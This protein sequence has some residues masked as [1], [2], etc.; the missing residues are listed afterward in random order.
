MTTIEPRKIVPIAAKISA[1]K[2]YFLNVIY[3][4][5]FL[6]C[7]AGIGTKFINIIRYNP[8]IDQPCFYHLNVEKDEENYIFKK[9]SKYE[10]KFGKEEI[11]NENKNL[12]QK[13]A[14]SPQIN[15]E[16]IFY[17]TELNEVEFIKDKEYLLTHDLCDVPGL[18]EY[19]EEKTNENKKL[20]YYND[21]EKIVLKG[22]EE[23]GIVYNKPQELNMN[24]KKQEDIK[25]IE[26]DQDDI[27]YEVDIEK[28]TYLTEVFKIIK[29]YI[30]GII[31][32]LSTQNYYHEENFEIIA[33]L[34]KVIDKEI[35]NCLIILNKIDLSQS[36][37]EDINKCKGLFI[38]KFPKCKTFNLNLNTFIPLSAFKL[39]N[40]LLMR[41]SFIHLLKYHFYNYLPIVMGEKA[42]EGKYF[43]DY[44]KNIIFN[45][46]NGIT[47]EKI[48]EE[49]AELNK[50]K[51]ISIIN[52][53]IKKAIREL[54]ERYK[55]D[56]INFGIEEKDLED[57][58]E[59]EDED[60]DDDDNDNDKLKSTYIVKMIYVLY[61]KKKLIP[62]I[63]EE[64]NKLLNYFTVKNQKNNE[65]N[66]KTKEDDNSEINKLNENLIIE[67]ESFAKE[68]KD[69]KMGDEN[70]K[71]L[72]NEIAEF[73]EYLKI[74]NVIFIPFLGPSNAGKSTIING[75][76]GKDILPT[77]LNEC[78]K[79]G[80]LIRYSNSDDITI[81][82]SN[83]IE[84]KDI[85]GKIN[86]YFNSKLYKDL[87]GKG[88]EEVKNTLNSLNCDYNEKEKDSFYYIKTRIKI[89]DDMGL[90][91]SLKNMIYLIDFPGFGTGGRNIFENKNIY[92]K[93]MSICNSFIFVVR[94]SVIKENTCQ[95]K[96]KEIFDLAKEGKK[97]FFSQFIKSC[98]FILNN[99]IDQSCNE[100]DLNKAKGEIK[101]MLNFKKLENENEKI[102]NSDE[103][104]LC[105]FN[106]KYYDNYCSNYNYFY[107]LDNLF[108]SEL[109]NY[110]KNLIS[111]YENPFSFRKSKNDNE[112]FD[113][114]YNNI[115][116]KIKN[117]FE[118]KNVKKKLINQEI[119]S[120][121]EE[122]MKKNLIEINKNENLNLADKEL[123]EIKEKLLKIIT[124]GQNKLSELETLKESNIENF[125]VILQSQ[126]S[127]INK[128]KLKN[129]EKI[130]DVIDLL[131][132]FFR[133]DFNER[134]KDL[135]E[136]TNINYL[137]RINER[138]INETLRLNEEMIQN[139][140]NVFKKNI[141]LSLFKHKEELI[142]KLKSKNYSII[143]EEI[144]KELSAKLKGLNVS[145]EAFI[146]FNEKQNEKLIEFI[147][148]IFKEFSLKDKKKYKIIHAY[149]NFRFYMSQLLG[150]EN[151]NFEEELFEELKNS[152]EN[153][154]SILFK[155]GII[156]W[157]NSLFSDFY[158]I[159]NII[160]ILID[161][162][163]KSINTIF[164]LI[165][166]E[167]N[168]YFTKY[169]KKIHLL[170]KSL[171]FK[172][173][174]EQEKKWKK[175]CDSY[176]QKRT[177]INQIKN[178]L[179]NILGKNEKKNLGQTID[180]GE[181]LDEEEKEEEE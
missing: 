20:V 132:M 139:L 172:F 55:A 76:I 9:D 176:E 148:E 35:K 167:S 31:I 102:E 30:D 13:L 96:L 138:E 37:L 81:Y 137:L 43:I 158:Y 66:Y 79:R 50:D 162:S 19:Q 106:A 124:F 36:P 111:L 122:K 59:E 41:K 42:S 125:K 47:N 165:K 11:I 34:R 80:I 174:D 16:D 54:K 15:Y 56:N 95:S 29:N 61:K 109:N 150:N 22:V 116:Q 160:D 83:F 46:E 166:N 156:N 48:K 33:K 141:K 60:E 151:K 5:D 77:K 147:K 94:N 87:I 44:L 112:F 65:I 128:I 69:S 153:S 12:N 21:F 121:L 170:V 7:K 175:L 131:D 181:N 73:I 135:K 178:N 6:E 114:F 108:K 110:K 86:Y 119:N 85:F 90:N 70:I 103:I 123:E 93:V 168:N 72:L 88:E 40:E 146:N 120:N 32:V 105:F 179:F 142:E 23:Y 14:D 163:S 129:L 74:Y 67:F 68:I 52:D 127:Y 107:D 154:R 155:K 100:S 149:D 143:L 45:G 161:T 10:T 89:F 171:T 8:N 104:K 82:K 39:K 62:P 136:I 157:F 27:F 113:Y 1:G 173:N 17:M 3:N 118:I 75:L 92:K 152:C 78:T 159:D 101:Y 134:K 98:L 164:D 130:N 140:K 26:K 18:S 25:N 169:L 51:N 97:K 24:D 144:N 58:N 63:S 117:L 180:K 99:D 64:T 115:M 91:D 38:Q 71:N 126:I 28:K 49:V 84:Q 177:K 145:I 133:K 57:N 2:S 53:Q 4:I